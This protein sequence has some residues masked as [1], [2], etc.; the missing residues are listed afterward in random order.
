MC[1]L[2]A[3]GCLVGVT[4]V[5]ITLVAPALVAPALVAPAVAAFVPAGCQS[6]IECA[7]QTVRMP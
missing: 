4:W 5:A 3:V 6:S 1:A 2:V 7:L